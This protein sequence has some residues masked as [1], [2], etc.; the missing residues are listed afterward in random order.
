MTDLTALDAANTALQKDSKA[1]ASV[2]RYGRE[3]TAAIHALAAPPVPPPPAPPVPA[4]L[5][6]GLDQLGGTLAACSHLR[7][8]TYAAVVGDWQDAGL[9]AQVSGLGFAYTCISG[10]QGTLPVDLTKPGAY[11][12]SVLAYR[13]LYGFAGVYMDNTTYGV[14]NLLPFV[15]V[16]GPALKAEGL[17][18]M[19]NT[20]AFVSNNPDSDTGVLWSQW[21]AKIAPCV[22]HV[23]LEY[24]QQYS[25]GP[26]L[27]QLRD[28]A[29][30]AL[31]QKCPATVHAAGA[32]FVGLTY[33]PPSGNATYAKGMLAAVAAPGDVFMYHKSD[34][35]DPYDPAWTS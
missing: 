22:T 30:G 6:V 12:A 17:K 20:A 28:P 25:G 13:K 7:D 21:A 16:V 35:S 18:V 8:G 23:A 33:G 3:A 24:W 34:H 5:G 14:A 26:Q 11:V 19:A 4:G 2:K 31:W 15:Q 27:G 1:A 10:P 9:L 29:N 32:S